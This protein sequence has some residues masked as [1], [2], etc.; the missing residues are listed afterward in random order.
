MPDCC[1]SF[2]YWLSRSPSLPTVCMGP[3]IAPRNLATVLSWV[4]YRGLLVIALLAVGNLFCTGLP[5]DPRSGRRAPDRTPCFALAS[6]ASQQ[7]AGHRPVHG[8]ALRATSCSISGAFR[9]PRRGSWWPIS[10]SALV[11]DVLFAGRELLQV[12]CCPIGQFNFV[13]VHAVAHRAARARRWHLSN[14]PHGGLHQGPT[15][16]TGGD[17]ETGAD[18]R[19]PRSHRRTTRLRARAVPAHRRLGTSTA[20]CASTACMRAR[21]T[22]S[23]SATRLP[24]D[25]LSDSRR[26]VR[27]RQ[28]DAASGH[29]CTGRALHL[30]CDDERLCHDEPSHTCRAVAGG[31]H[32]H[33]RGGSRPGSPLCRRLS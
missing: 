28:V 3:R 32:R 23:R 6:S 17:A 25:E 4:H 33:R 15:P 24:G 22:T 29:R 13:V 26:T 31:N 12:P 18:A 9:E 2:L 10:P 8:R 19:R 30:R 14:M 27:H 11:I 1:C 5:D 20:R 7:V 16:A 21:T